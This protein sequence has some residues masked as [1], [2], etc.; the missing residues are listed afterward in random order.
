MSDKWYRKSC[1]PSGTMISTRVRLARN[2]SAYPFP[3]RMTAEQ[4]QEVATLVTEA[5]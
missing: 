2:L 5:A 1:D 4:R 3:F